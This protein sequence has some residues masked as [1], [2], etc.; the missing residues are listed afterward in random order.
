MWSPVSRRL[1]PL[2][3]TRSPAASPASPTPATHKL[4]QTAVPLCG[5]VAGHSSMRGWRPHMEDA[6]LMEPLKLHGHCLLAVFDG[7]AGARVADFAAAEL[8][9]VLEG[10]DEWARYSVALTKKSSVAV[11]LL[12]RALV[13][14]F[15]RLDAM[16]GDL[17][18]VARGL[19]ISG[20]AAVVAVVTPTHIVVANLGD[21]RCVVRSGGRALSMSED[22]KPDL[23][24][25][26]LR[27]RLAGGTVEANRVN[28]ELAMSRA[29]GDFR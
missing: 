17:P 13:S 4:H 18:E 15:V 24:E 25:E 6:F 21:S 7:H 3:Q 14:A 11:D 8:V 27:I 22:H 12:G 16:I 2:R 28:G 26:E 5:R 23:P 19:D 9:S 10:S 1:H 20:A 29:L